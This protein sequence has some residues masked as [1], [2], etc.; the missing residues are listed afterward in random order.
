MPHPERYVRSKMTQSRFLIA[1]AATRA[2]R[3]PGKLD[4]VRFVVPSLS[5][6]TKPNPTEDQSPPGKLAKHGSVWVK[7]IK[8]HV[9]GEDLHLN[10]IEYDGDIFFDFGHPKYVFVIE[11]S[12]SN[13]GAD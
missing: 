5:E 13:K 11:P 3:S 7:P 9:N 12:A 6:N 1:D 4:V 2:M 10:R 8:L